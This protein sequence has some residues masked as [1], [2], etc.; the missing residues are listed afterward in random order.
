MKKL[1]ALALCFVMCFSFVACGGKGE[2]S[3]NTSVAPTEKTTGKIS[4]EIL[5]AKPAKD[6]NDKDAIVVEYKFKNGTQKSLAF[7]FST[8]VTVKQGDQ[9]LKLAAVPKSDSFDSA[10]STKPIKPN[11]EIVAQVAYTP[12]DMKTALD[13]SVKLEQGEDKT[14]ITKQVPLA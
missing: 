8:K 3:S 1:L 14:E 2:E 13:I 10:T 6:T 5:S 11:E 12:V 7:K 9:A 4:V